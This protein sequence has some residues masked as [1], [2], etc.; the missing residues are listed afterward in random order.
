MN[1]S[2][3]PREPSEAAARHA[4]EVAQRIKGRVLALRQTWIMLAEDLWEF[5]QAKLWADLGY[6]NFEQWLAEPEVEL[7]A[8]YVY[9]LLAMWQQ[10][11]VQRGVEPSRLQELQVSKVREVL[12]AI[13]RGIVT[14]DEGLS[15]AS[16]LKRSDL[17][18]R[19][20]GKSSD[21]YTAGPDT[22]T[23]VRTEQEPQWTRCRCCGSLI[24]VT[25]GNE[26][27]DEDGTVV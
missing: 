3:E 21:G 24:R 18:E 4:Y 12:P 25:P 22:S 6:E 26:E 11:V 20:R 2:P 1:L 7:G 13:R 5:H 14:V 15:D 8:R 19:Y 10:L 17:E 23:E 16:T 9:D 27:Q